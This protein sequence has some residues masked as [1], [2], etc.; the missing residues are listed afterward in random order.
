MKTAW[1]VK[2]GTI[3]SITTAM[4]PAARHEVSSTLGKLDFMSRPT[5]VVIPNLSHRYQLHPREC[6]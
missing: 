1:L 3:S 2:A 4:S 6:G 5:S